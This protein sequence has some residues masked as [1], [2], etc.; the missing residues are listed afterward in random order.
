V[1]NCAPCPH[2]LALGNPFAVSGWCSQASGCQRV[3]LQPIFIFKLAQGELIPAQTA[4]RWGVMESIAL[5][6]PMEARPVLKD[7]KSERALRGC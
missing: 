2:A 3:A 1:R 7:H 6:S 5:E 4:G